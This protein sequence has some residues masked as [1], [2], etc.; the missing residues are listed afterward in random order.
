MTLKKL[1][2]FAKPQDALS[3]QNKSNRTLG[4]GLREEERIGYSG[5]MQRPWYLAFRI[6]N[7][8]ECGTQD[9]L[10]HGSSGDRESCS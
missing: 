4:R 3:L 8:R 2:N 10:L 9:P 1:L 7:L 5:E 6:W